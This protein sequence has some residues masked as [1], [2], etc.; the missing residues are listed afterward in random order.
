MSEPMKNDSVQSFLEQLASAAPAP[1][2][3]AAAA[4]S[5]A[6]GAALISMVANLTLG[7][8]NYAAVQGQMRGT[9]DQSERQRKKLMA[10]MAEDEAAFTRVTDAMKMPHDTAELAAAREAAMQEALKA[11]TNVPMEIAQA[12]GAVLKMG[13]PMAEIANRQLISDD[14]VAALLAE[15]GMKSAALNVMINLKHIKD[16]DFVAKTQARLDG[17]LKLSALREQTYDYVSARL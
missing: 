15:A 13:L 9:R 6:M 5:G 12:C 1:G 17:L 8:K 3:G 14:G 16:A 10:L 4:L 7:K 2:G 11:A